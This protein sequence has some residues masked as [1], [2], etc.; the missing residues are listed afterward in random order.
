MKTN[1][2]TKIKEVGKDE[3]YCEFWKCLEC[4]NSNIPAGSN[5][6]SECGREIIKPTIP[7]DPNQ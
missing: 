2:F 3:L 1:E 6:C 5:Y 7:P 4:G